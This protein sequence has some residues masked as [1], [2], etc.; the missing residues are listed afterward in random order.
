MCCD[1]LCCAMSTGLTQM[2][3]Y[4]AGNT[5]D[6][7]DGRGSAMTGNGSSSRGARSGEMQVGVGFACLVCTPLPCIEHVSVRVSQH[8]AVIP[9]KPSAVSCCA[10]CCPLPPPRQFD[11]S[12][13]LTADDFEGTRRAAM[14]AVRVPQHVIQLLADLRTYLQVT[15]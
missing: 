11:P 10:V 1:V 3:D 2:L 12:A 15:G 6:E 7:E 9:S 4:Y 13:R 5:Y 8:A 14:S